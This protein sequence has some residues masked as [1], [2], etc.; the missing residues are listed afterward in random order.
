MWAAEAILKKDVDCGFHKDFFKE[1][2][3]TILKAGEKV[4][5]TKGFKYKYA[6]WNVGNIMDLPKKY[7]NEDTIKVFSK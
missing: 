6:I 1:D 3:C 2:V 5:I 7:I 4:T